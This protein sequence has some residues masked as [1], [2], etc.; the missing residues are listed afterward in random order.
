MDFISGINLDFVVLSVLFFLPAFLGNA[1]P[2]VF[3]KIPIFRWVFT[4]PVDGGK[5]LGKNR[6][7]GQTKTW[8][9]LMA[10]G[11]VGI[12]IGVLNYY[13]RFLPF[14]T[15]FV[16]FLY[17]LLASL[18]ALIGDLIKSFLKRRLNIDSSRPWPVFDQLDFVVGAWLATG[19]CIP[20]SQTWGYFLLALVI[21]IPGHLLLNLLAYKL[22][23]KKVWW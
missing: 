22:G 13:L 15:G 21:T 6:L 9:G 3:A 4:L 20:L 16:L 7:F 14:G 11:I 8:G 17:P 10:A 5:F 23:F 1:A 12:L 18:G 19:L 2:V